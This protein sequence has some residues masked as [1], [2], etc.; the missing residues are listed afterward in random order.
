MITQAQGATVQPKFSAIYADPPW[1]YRD[2]GKSGSMKPSGSASHYPTDLSFEQIAGINVAD[3]ASHDSLC[4]LW[5]TNPLLPVGVDVLRSWGFEFVTI[6]FVWVKTGRTANSEAELKRLLAP[7]VDKSVVRSIVDEMKPHLWPAFQIGQGSH[8]RANPEL[9]LLG[10]RGKGLKRI[11]AGV[12]SEVL[13]PPRGHS[14]KPDEVS[15]RVV[16]LLGDV[17]RVELFARRPRE[18]WSIWGNEVESDIELH[19]PD[20]GEF[21]WSGKQRVALRVKPRSA[22]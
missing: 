21:V 18:G 11:S 4:F 9:C 6:A 2:R 7:R 3:I 8:T 14:V 12:R 10:R 13:V 15:E 20:P 19:V 5:V 22:R 1:P 16:K 17:P